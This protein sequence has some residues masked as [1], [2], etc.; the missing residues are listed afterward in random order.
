L[1]KRILVALK[2][3]EI[4]EAILPEVAG[5]AC[6]LG[7]TL[8]LVQVTHT[9]SRDAS[10]HLRE[11][12]LAYLG[13]RA[14]EL[15]CQGMGVEVVV[16]EGEPWE[17]ICGLAENG[18]IDLLVMGKHHHSEVRDLISGSAT[19]RVIRSCRISVLLVSGGAEEL[20]R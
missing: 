1:Y 14:G 11:Q 16:R 20:R 10:T 4:D 5:L 15:R 13:A 9:H 12:A 17:E 3:D 18:S 19:E 7:A 6:A 8:V 2:G